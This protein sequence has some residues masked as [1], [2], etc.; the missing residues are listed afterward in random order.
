MLD[1]I[2]DVYKTSHRSKPGQHR[3]HVDLHI[4]ALKLYQSALIRGR[5]SRW[6]GRLLHRD[7]GLVDLNAVLQQRRIWS[8][9]I[10][11]AQPVV[12]QSILGS[13][14]RSQDFDRFFRPVN[15]ASRQRWLAVAMHMLGGVVLPPVELVEIG[16]VHFVRDGHLRISVARAL[17]L[18]SI[19]AQVV[20]LRLKQPAPW[21]STA[22]VKPTLKLGTV[23]G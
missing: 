10:D 2:Y 11:C 15:E 6:F 12:L 23:T 4:A 14:S 7:R 8:Y 20:H 5:L 3:Q 13:E 21:K 9:H 18:K 19:D 22:T 17:G 1:P 16:G